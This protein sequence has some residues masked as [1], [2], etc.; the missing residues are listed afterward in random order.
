MNLLAPAKAGIYIQACS[1]GT[2]DAGTENRALVALVFSTKETRRGR[3]GRFFFLNPA[4]WER[5]LSSY[6]SCHL[7]MCY[8]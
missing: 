4:A 6:H 8:S 7:T 5:A 3:G 2:S 1:G